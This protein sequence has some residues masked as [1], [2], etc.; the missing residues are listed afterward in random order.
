MHGGR[1]WGTDLASLRVAAPGRKRW[2]PR[3]PTPS[4]QRVPAAAHRAVYREPMPD[5]PSPALTDPAVTPTPALI[6]AALGEAA[7]AWHDLLTTLDEEFGLAVEWR[8]YRD[9]GWLGK[10]LKGK[11]NL[12]WLCVW[13]GYG[14]ITFYFPARHRDTLAALPL[15]A[16]LRA[17]VTSGERVGASI[18]VKV[19]L[20]TPTDVDAATT[21]LRHKM[22]AR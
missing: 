9:G 3:P 2:R 12:A 20:R 18:A 22:T 17:D 11:K 7:P 4:D 10:V 21:L 6:D 8:W 5:K 1:R 13:P 14:S 15:P 19:D 16:E